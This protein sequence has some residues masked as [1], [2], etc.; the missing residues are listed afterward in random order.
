MPILTARFILESVVVGSSYVSPAR[1]FFLQCFKRRI[2]LRDEVKV[3]GT[4]LIS[5]SDE[6]GLK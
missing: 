3:N 1:R 6:G 4:L 5:G 2:E